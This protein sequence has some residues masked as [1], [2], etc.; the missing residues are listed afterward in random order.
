[1]KIL[2]LSGCVC[3]VALVV[4]NYNV[5]NTQATLGWGAAAEWSL[6]SLIQELI[7]EK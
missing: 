7:S 5:G 1:M 4:L 2:A 3:A 6:N